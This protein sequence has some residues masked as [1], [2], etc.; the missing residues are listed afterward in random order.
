MSAKFRMA[1]LSV[2]CAALAACDGGAVSVQPPY[3]GI[4]DPGMLRYAISRGSILTEVAG[5]PFDVPKAE[6]EAA[7]TRSM[8]GATFGRQASFTT[9]VPA[10]YSSPY[11]VAIL[12][13]PALGAQANRLCRDPGQSTAAEPD[14]IRAMAAFCSNDKAITSIVGSTNRVR[15]PEDPAFSELIRRMTLD[16]F[17]IQDLVKDDK[18]VVILPP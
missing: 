12:L 1:V 18:G 17:P 15:S 6:V 9:E 16:L 14:R 11:R 13:E 2:V 10:D 5:N 3:V 4:Y 7:V 8:T